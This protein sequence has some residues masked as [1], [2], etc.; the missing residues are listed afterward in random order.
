MSSVDNLSK[1]VFD[2]V[3]SVTARVRGYLSNVEG[4]SYLS[5][6]IGDFLRGGIS[7]YTT[8]IENTHRTAPLLQKTVSKKFRQMGDRFR[9]ITGA[10]QGHSPV[11]LL[12]GGGGL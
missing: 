6:R 8:Y 7:T 5:P 2:I 4:G 3:F 11:P 10:L 1:D 12:A 9:Q